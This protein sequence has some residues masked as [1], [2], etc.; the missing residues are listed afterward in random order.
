MILT[1][2]EIKRQVYEEN[3]VIEPFN[4]KQINPNSYN[5]RINDEIMVL[6]SDCKENQEKYIKIP[7]DGYLLEPKNVYLSTTY[8]MI[9]SKNYVV[10]LIGRSSIARLGLFLQISA[11]L[12]NL[13]SIH[14]WTLEM[15][16]TQPIKIYPNM[17]IGQV[18]FWKPE[19]KITLYQGE[20]QNFNEAKYGLYGG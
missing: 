18:S 2:K 10:S 6:P 14:K 17:I 7:E 16:C 8:E 19:G 13:G 20:Y 15:V 4:D 5:Y 11:D 9:G 12:S 3:I 1:G